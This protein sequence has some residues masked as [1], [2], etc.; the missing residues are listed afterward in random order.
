M[1]VKLQHVQGHRPKDRIQRRIVGVDRQRDL[2]QALRCAQ[3]QI[4]RDLDRQVARAFRKKT[5]P[6]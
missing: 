6:A 4:P 2:A 1:A 5:N 3:R